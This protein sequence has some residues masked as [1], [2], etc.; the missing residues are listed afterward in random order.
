MSVHGRVLPSIALS[1]ALSGCILPV[2]TG[3]PLPATTV[4]Q[5]KV[6]VAIAGEAPVLDLIANNKN[7]DPNQNDYVSTYGESPAAAATLTFAYGLGDD[8]DF[9]IAGEGA[10]SY[11]VLPLPTGASIGMRQHLVA[12]DSVDLAIAGRIGGVTTG[13]TRYD[14]NGNAVNDAASAYYGAVQGVIQVHSG[15]FRPLAAINLMPFH[16]SRSPQGYPV[17]RFTGFASSATVGLM[18]VRPRVELGPYITVTDFE[19]QTF[20]GGRFVSGGLMIALRRD[21]SLPPPQQLIT[22]MPYYGPPAA[23]LPPPPVQ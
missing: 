20:S 22:P 16:I 5:G 4:G 7:P 1:V 2:S 10:L 19:S 8:T 14:S 11:G 13:T 18:F 3:A 17:Q 6:G 12:T 9:E 15:S 23:P 21:R